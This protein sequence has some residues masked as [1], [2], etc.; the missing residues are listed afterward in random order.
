MIKFFQVRY[1]NVLFLF[2][3]LYVNYASVTGGLGGKSI[4]ELSDKYDNLF[5]PAPQTF[6]IWSII[7]TLLL[8]T[9]IR[10]LFIQQTSSNKI[11]YYFLVLFLRG[12][13]VYYPLFFSKIFCFSHSAFIRFS[14]R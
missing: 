4:R 11:Y 9:T 7:Y 1:L 12:K 14:F 13:K 10:Q 6:G 5:T 3:T 2:L 8:I